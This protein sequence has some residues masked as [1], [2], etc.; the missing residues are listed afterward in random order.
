[1]SNENENDRELINTHNE[2]PDV[3]YITTL[4][5][6]NEKLLMEIKQVKDAVKETKVKRNMDHIIWSII[7]YNLYGC[8]E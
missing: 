6:E 8:N 4:E 3:I 2:F 1:M 5:L 7:S